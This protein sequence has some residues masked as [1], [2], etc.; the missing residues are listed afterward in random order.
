MLFRSVHK[1]LDG[2]GF[3]MRSIDVPNGPRLLKDELPD[4]HS[5]QESFTDEVVRCS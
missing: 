2:P 3:V 5:F 4:L 1:V